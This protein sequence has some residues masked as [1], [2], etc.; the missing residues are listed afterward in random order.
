MSNHDPESQGAE[1][2]A[3]PDP[4][5]GLAPLFSHR[6]GE[7]RCA[8]RQAAHYHKCFSCQHFP[9]AEARRPIPGTAPPAELQEVR[10]AARASEEGA[11]RPVVAHDAQLK[12]G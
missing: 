8:D 3:C 9:G 11:P 4:L 7:G 6:I 5:D 12:V 10:P 2:R 1:L